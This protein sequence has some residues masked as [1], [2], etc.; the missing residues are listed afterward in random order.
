MQPDERRRRR[1]ELILIATVTAIFL[2]LA[3]FETRLVHLTNS[4]SWSGNVTFFL[5]IN[6]NLL[7]L[8][9]VVFLVMRQAVK[10][11]LE[12]RHGIFGSRLR[13][14]LAFAFLGLTLVP[15]VLLFIVA[16]G[17]LNTAFD[18]WFNVRVDSALRGALEV[19]QTY[20]Q[21]AANNALFFARQVSRD[22][23]KRDLFD[24]H[25]PKTRQ[26][27]VDAKRAEYGLAGLSLLGAQRQTL[28]RSFND[29]AARMPDLSS[30]SVAELFAAKEVLRTEKLGRGHVIRCGILATADDGTPLGAVVVDYLVPRDV[31]DEAG[32]ITKSYQEYRQLSSMKQPIRSAYTLT[33]A[34]VTIVVVFIAMWFGFQQAKAITTPLQ[35]LAEGTR[36]VAQGNWDYR[37]EAGS[38]SD[39]EALGNSLNQMTQDLRATNSELVERRNYLARILSN[40]AAGVVSIDD[41]GRITML[42]PAAER[43]LGVRLTEAFG[44][45][46]AEVLGRADLSA[47][48]ELVAEAAAHPRSEVEQQI[49]LTGGE[50]IMT[51]LVSATALSDDSGAARGV[52]L[53]FEDV[54]HLLRVQRMEAWR[55]VARRLAHE[56][57]NP[58]T[59]I[60]LS[61][62]RLRKR[63]ADKLPPDDREVFDECT[64]T[65]VAQVDEMKRLVN[66][67]ST[68]ARLPAVALAIDDINSVIDEALVLFRE[69][70]PQI[71]FAFDRGASVPEFNL[72]RA[73]IKRVLINLL[74]NAVAA[75][76][77]EP[78]AGRI[79]LSTRFIP[80]RGMVRIEVADNGAG[81]SREVKMRLFEPYF[82][83]KRDGTG[84]GLAIVSAIVADHQGYVRVLE[85]Q[86]RGSRFIIEL[87]SG[88]RQAPERVTAQA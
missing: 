34:L 17:L 36:E 16:Q 15:S 58:L 45:T 87:P 7:L 4:S 67:F 14:R 43:M 68:F 10:L 88:K 22:A 53:F 75:C 66:E 24:P 44:K 82:S 46:A 70:H 56:I 77:A 52:L 86:P 13:T 65:I 42:N 72:D 26:K 23:A 37:F 25:A 33:M 50:Q 63:Y 12:R 49:K 3:I 79:G 61:A 29:A 51:A 9:L 80:E 85:N 30:E 57:K 5:L 21:S 48:A 64:T 31:S 74:D 20:Y 69:A 81:M 73:A 27:Y 11:V 59:P 18:R 28:T 39:T 41:N 35:N 6:L 84:L 83:T 60:Q 55:E 1:R 62:Q 71:E 76:D 47:V 38:D 32:E 8:V 40:I 54:T 78:V 2:V 19:A